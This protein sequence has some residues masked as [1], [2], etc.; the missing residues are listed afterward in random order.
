MNKKNAPRSLR[1]DAAINPVGSKLDR[2]T[3]RKITKA[4]GLKAALF[5]VSYAALGI[6]A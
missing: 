2:N 5:S 4:T 1:I 6:L 3:G